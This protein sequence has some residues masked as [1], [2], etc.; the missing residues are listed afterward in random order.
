MVF[1][2]AS[3]F[4]AV[5]PSYG[6]LSVPEPP[7]PSVRFA[8]QISKGYGSSKSAS[9]SAI[10]S[11]SPFNRTPSDPTQN[12]K[13]RQGHD[14]GLGYRCKRKPGDGACRPTEHRCGGVYVNAVNLRN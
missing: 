5:L 7:T 1:I 11:L 8:I 12:T 3:N 4:A 9:S 2:S 13:P 14:A 6:S 10:Y